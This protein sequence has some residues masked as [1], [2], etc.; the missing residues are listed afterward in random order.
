[1]HG[2]KIEAPCINKSDSI[3]VIHGKV[4]HLGLNLIER[5]ESETIRSILIERYTNGSF[6]DLRD[7]MKR[8]P[9]SLEQLT[10]LLRVNAFR[11]TDK[12]KKELL[13]DA[14]FILKKDKRT[15][16]EKT[17]FNEKPKE[18]SL[19][20]LYSH[21]L[22]TA[23]DELEIIGFSSS[24]SPFELIENLP[25]TRL[26][27]RDL[28]CKINESVEII[29]YLVHVKR[30]GTSKGSTMSFGVFVDFKGHW[31]DTVQFPNVMKQYPFR[32][33]GCYLIKGIVIKEFDFISIQVSELHRLDNIKLEEPSTR[34]KAIDAN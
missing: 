4:I 6:K 25:N 26:L 16:P 24:V 13:W 12:S 5:L 10:I 33:P 7:F 14:H 30:T 23:Y 21:P 20:E 29:G 11:F 34:L 1:M 18:F 15:K 31:I 8:V 17:L 3:T 27:A 19:P 28:Y 32:G 22:E 9:V 2:A